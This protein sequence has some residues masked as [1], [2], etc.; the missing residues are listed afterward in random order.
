MDTFSFF[1]G[2]GFRLS[3][4]GGIEDI[5]RFFIVLKPES[6]NLYRRIVVGREYLS[7]IGERERNWG[8]VDK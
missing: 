3:R 4:I 7:D 2:R 8:F 5:Q 1:T 6:K